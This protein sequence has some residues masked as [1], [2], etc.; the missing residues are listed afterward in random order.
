MV[1]SRKLAERH[2]ALA[3]VFADGRV[4]FPALYRGTGHRMLRGAERSGSALRMRSAR[5]PARS[6]KALVLDQIRKLEPARAGLAVPKK[7]TWDLVSR[8][9]VRRDGSRRRCRT[10]PGAEPRLRPTATRRTSASMRSADLPGRRAPGAGVSCARPKRSAC[11]IDHDVGRGD[12][13]ARLPIRWFRPT[14]GSHLPRTRASRRGVL[15]RR[16]GRGS[17]RHSRLQTPLSFRRRLGP[18]QRG[19]PRKR[20][21]DKR[22]R[23]CP[24]HRSRAR[25]GE[26][27]SPASRAKPSWS[28][29]EYASRRLCVNRG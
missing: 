20:W 13:D 4:A 19:R 25:S 9:L 14:L 7:V 17:D 21:Q 15:R 12:V 11:S 27:R 28:S 8:D 10:T 5:S 2:P 18:P 29:P 1:A 24:L 23:P 16:V 6:Q 22:R 26:T 3:G